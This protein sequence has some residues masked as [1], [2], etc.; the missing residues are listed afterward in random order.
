MKELNNIL[1]DE[2]CQEAHFETLPK[3][4]YYIVEV[5]RVL[6]FLSFLVCVLGFRNQ[7]LDTCTIECGIEDLVSLGH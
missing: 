3:F 1:C 6:I 4:D 5:E 7:Y 2:F